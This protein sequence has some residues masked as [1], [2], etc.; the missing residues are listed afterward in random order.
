MDA[1][2]IWPVL[3]VLLAVFLVVFLVV[4]IF[5]LVQKNQAAEAAGFNYSA[6]T[7]PRRPGGAIVDAVGESPSN[8][9]CSPTAGRAASTQVQL[10]Q[11][12]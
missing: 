2:G 4:A 12:W 5:K 7:R 10:R 11:R 8:V 6:K 1:W 3:G 9:R